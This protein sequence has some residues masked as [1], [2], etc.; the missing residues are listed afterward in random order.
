MPRSFVIRA[1]IMIAI[2][3][4]GLAIP[5]P[6]VAATDRYAVGVLQKTFVRESPVWGPRTLAATIWY[7]ALAAADASRAIVDAL[8]AEGRFPV[9]VYSHGGCGGA[10][11]AVEPVA[12]PIVSSG[13]VFVQFPHPGSTS[14]D[15]VSGGERYTRALLERPDDIVHV[16]NELERL[17]DDVSWHLHGRVETRLVGIIGHS[18]GGQTALMMPAKDPRVRAAF[19]LSPSVAHPDSPAA[20]WEAIRAARVP[21]LIVHGERDASWTSEGPLKAF[22][23]LPSG[24]PKAYLEV[25]GMGHTPSSSDD[26]S[27][28]VRYATALFQRYLKGDESAAAI[29]AP[30][31][32]PAAVSFK[33]SLRE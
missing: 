19:S 10:A 13:F 7:P 22:D 28:I 8:P 12:L 29:L 31:A 4:C 25:G 6:E 17:N 26:V 14:D 24:T 16:V 1:S 20:L 3:C 18:Q 33:G 11:K 32:A 5:S 30:S 9:V 23:S 2:L 27:L 21:V 15:C